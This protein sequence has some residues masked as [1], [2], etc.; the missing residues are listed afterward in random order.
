M[1]LIP[2]QAAFDDM[3]AKLRSRLANDLLN[4]ISHHAAQR[5]VRYLVAQTT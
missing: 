1:D 2:C 3:Y 4:A 5:L